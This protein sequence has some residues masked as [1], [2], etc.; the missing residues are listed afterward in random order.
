MPEGFTAAFARRLDEC[1]AIEVKEAAIGDAIYAGRVL[2]APGN[3][4]LKARRTAVGDLVVLS[5]E[6]PVNGH[7][8]SAS[9]LFSSVAHEFRRNAVGLIMTGM[10]E[11]GAEALGE[12]KTAGGITIAQDEHSCVVFGMPK[13]AIEYGHAMHV[14]SLESLSEFLVQQC[15]QSRDTADTVAASAAGASSPG[16]F[17]CNTRR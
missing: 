13:A 10:G 14:V 16:G 1:C 17:L 6:P 12:I 4:H 9:T 3:R 2:I 8:P 11:D 5:D 7:R 15:C